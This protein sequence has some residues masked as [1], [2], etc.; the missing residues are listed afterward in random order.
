[1]Y[2]QQRSPFPQNHIDRTRCRGHRN[3]GR[4][5][6]GSEEA[7]RRPRD[8]S[9]R[10]V[11]DDLRPEHHWHKVVRVLQGQGHEEMNMMPA[12]DICLHMCM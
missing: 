11:H 9:V 8:V 4:N 12:R 5:A 6:N 10:E 7:T 1:M 2:G 3:A